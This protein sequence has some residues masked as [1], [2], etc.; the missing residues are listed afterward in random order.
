VAIIIDSRIFHH[1]G[2]IW[3]RGLEVL[4]KV[5]VLYLVSTILG[6]IIRQFIMFRLD[7]S[8]ATNGVSLS[9]SLSDFVLH[10]FEI[11]LILLILIRGIGF[12]I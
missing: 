9:I 4:S 8:V 2:R 3:M 1:L 5:R 12:E 11:I 6:E 10:W 7:N